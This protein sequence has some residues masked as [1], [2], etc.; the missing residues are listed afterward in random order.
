MS[1]KRFLQEKRGGDKKVTEG[2]RRA[3]PAEGGTRKR[4]TT[5]NSGTGREQLE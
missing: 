1:Q 3:P 4:T 5:P 2:K